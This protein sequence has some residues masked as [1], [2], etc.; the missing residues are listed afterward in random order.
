MK[1]SEQMIW[2]LRVLRPVYVS[3][4]FTGEVT[5]KRLSAMVVPNI[6][7]G[8]FAARRTWWSVVDDM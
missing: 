3:R 6:L 4:L 7:V 1:L 5:R 8:V 2:N